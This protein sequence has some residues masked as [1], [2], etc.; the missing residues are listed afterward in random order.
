VGW[1]HATSCAKIDVACHLPSWGDDVYETKL[2]ANATYC[3]QAKG[4]AN[5]I[6]ISYIVEVAT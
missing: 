4:G 3:S 1:W 6:I 5:I 2:M